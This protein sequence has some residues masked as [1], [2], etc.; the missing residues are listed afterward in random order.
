MSEGGVI[1]VF[2]FS[3]IYSH[4][5]PTP[6]R[7]WGCANSFLLDSTDVLWKPYM[8]SWRMNEAKLLCLKCCGRIFS[9]N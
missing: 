1:F 5:R 8:L 9:A 4:Q 3:F 7:K 2:I 6:R